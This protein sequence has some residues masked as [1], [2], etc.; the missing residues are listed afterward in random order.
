MTRAKA[1]TAMSN[2]RLATARQPL[3]WTGSTYTTGKRPSARTKSRSG[4]MSMSDDESST[5]I[6]AS[7]SSRA[8]RLARSGDTS[9][10]A[11]IT[12]VAWDCRAIR[13]VSSAMPRCLTRRR[14]MA[15]G[16]SRLGLVSVT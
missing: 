7:G 13:T 15:S 10:V 3:R 11:T 14:P 2:E 6:P 1:D 9:V 5:W 8:R 12:D 16:P 4:T